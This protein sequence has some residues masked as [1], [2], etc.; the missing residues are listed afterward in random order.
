MERYAKYQ[1]SGIAWLGEI[2]EHWECIKFKRLTPIKRGASPRPIADPVYFDP[3]GEYAWVRIADVTASERY[4]ETTTQKL[5]ELGKSYSVSLEPDELFL[6]IAGSVGKP[7]ITKIKCCIHDGFVYFPNLKA[8]KEFIYYIFSTGQPYLGLGKL[9]TQLNLNT[10][11]VG[12]IEIGLPPLEEQKLIAAY[13]DRKTAEIDE[14]IAQKERLIALYEEEKTAIIN[15]AITKGINPD[16]KLKPTAIDWLGD[17]PKH[18]KIQKL[19]FFVSKIEQGWSPSC[20]NY[21]VSKDE[22][23]ILKVGCVNGDYFN[24]EENKSLPIEMKPKTQYEIK[25]GDI[26]ISR[27]NTKELLGSAAIVVD[28]RLKLIFCDKLYRI[29]TKYEVNKN[30]LIRYLR[31]SLARFQYEREATGTS[32]SMQNIGQD[33]IKNLIIP[34]PPIEEQKTIA[35]YIEKEIARI[36]AKIAKTKRI[37]ELQKEYRTALISEAVTGKI[38]IPDLVS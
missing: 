8:N 20:H 33:T 37:I 29:I 11:T 12:G 3:D 10:D 21:P 27:A 6:S 30:Y 18:W 7:I 4:L 17:I 19:R 24:Q 26:L 38:K 32:I 14:L 25:D 13:L 36:D 22:W 9:G 1:D 28:L 5:S 15:E 34:F 31:S 23:G 2:P 35:K 16:V